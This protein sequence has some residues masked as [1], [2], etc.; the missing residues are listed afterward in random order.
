[1]HPCTQAGTHS[2]T[3]ARPH[4]PT[5]TLTPSLQFSPFVVDSQ[6]RLSPL[7]VR[8]VVPRLRRQETRLRLRFVSA[9]TPRGSSPYRFVRIAGKKRSLR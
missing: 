7:A 8:R 4:M 9:A 5:H 2:R 1:M 3:H 6:F